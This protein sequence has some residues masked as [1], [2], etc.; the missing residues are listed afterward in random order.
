MDSEFAPAER[1][2]QEKIEEQNIEVSSVFMIKEILDSITDKTILR[3]VLSNLLKNALEASR[4]ED[5]IAMGCYKIE[6]NIIFKIQNPA[7]IPESIQSQIFQRSF[8]TKGKGRG[9][10]AYSVRLL[11]TRYLKGTVDFTSNKAHGTEFIIKL[12]MEIKNEINYK[13]K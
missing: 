5:I 11:T 2:P 3:R 4:K 13:N 8:S 12:P 1:E 10:G 9:S 7:Y 6:G